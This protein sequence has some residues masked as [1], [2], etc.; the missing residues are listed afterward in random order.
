MVSPGFLLEGRYRLDSRIAAGGMGEVWR[1]TDLVLGREVAVKLLL[2]EYAW[3]A[4]G[5]TRFRA[6]ARHAGTLSHP[7]IAQVFDYSDGG[8]PDGEDAG[9]P[10]L[11]MELVDGPSL[12]ALLA[13]RPVGPAFALGVTAQVG[14]GLAAAHAAGLVHRDIKAGN[15]LIS[16][17]GLVKITDFG[18]A[19]APGSTPVTR[20]GEVLGTADYLAPERAA[21]APAGP[22][23]DLYALGVV[24]YECL[25][26]QRPFSGE[27]LAVALAHRERPLPPLP[28]DVPAGI[29]AL[30][31]DL[32][33]K[34]PA[35]RPASAAE[36]AARA[37]QLRA[38]LG[39]AGPSRPGLPVLGA[40]IVS[41]EPY[42]GQPA[43]AAPLV[44][45]AA[46]HQDATGPLAGLPPVTGGGPAEEP[47]AAR[48]RGLAGWIGPRT[49]ASLAGAAVVLAGLAGLAAWILSGHQG[50]AP[51]AHIS[52][53]T[54]PAARP[55]T[56]SSSPPGGN[57]D[58]GTAPA[59]PVNQ[60]ASKTPA[61]SPSHTP[62][63]T[64]TQP[65]AQT[66]APPPTRSS[67]PPPASTPTP[68]GPTPRPGNP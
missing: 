46:Q 67:S 62:A 36:V 21:G 6:E 7:N 10:Y 54:H 47:D 50:H 45:Q 66:P 35:A 56:H 1:G 58:A 2:P 64:R 31:A 40:A 26:G 4:E 28:P 25:T 15:L 51:P 32:T 61:P 43:A 48:R 11:V 29:A 23:A 41:A 3:E 33:A 12:A 49:R 34:D 53:R 63:R 22:P 55:D 9:R 44:A 60:P 19:H 39:G 18:I 5:A 27:P 13:S 30:V 42:A 38:D 68:T 59:A 17:A 20:T 24:A 8:A 16:K 37:E 52:A 57:A 14:A 65:P